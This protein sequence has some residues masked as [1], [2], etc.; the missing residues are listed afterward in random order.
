MASPTSPLQDPV[1]LS[2]DAGRLIDHPHADGLHALEMLSKYHK[3]LH[4]IIL[5]DLDEG[6]TAAARAYLDSRYPVQ[7][8]PGTS[9]LLL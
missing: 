2:A 5:L 4:R 1:P 8:A 6:L 3:C 9:T 7:R